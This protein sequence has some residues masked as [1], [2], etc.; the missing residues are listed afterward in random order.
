MLFFCLSVLKLFYLAKGFFTEASL[1]IPSHLFS[2]FESTLRNRKHL[3][4]MWWQIYFIFYSE[5]L[6]KQAFFSVMEVNFPFKYSMLVTGEM[7]GNT[8]QLAS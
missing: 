5:V 4:I 1:K 6:R 2:M 3:N 7:K 8:F